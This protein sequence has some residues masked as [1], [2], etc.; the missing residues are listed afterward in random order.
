MSNSIADWKVQLEIRNL[1]KDILREL[2]KLN[3]ESRIQKETKE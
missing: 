1:L 2:E 3:R